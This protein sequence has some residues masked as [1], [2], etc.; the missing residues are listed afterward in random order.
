MKI[1]MGSL[2]AP[3]FAVPFYAV[4]DKSHEEIWLKGGRGSG[5][6]S[7]ISLDII[8]GLMQD[9]EA[10]AIVYRKVAETLR[11]SVYAQMVWALDKL[12]LLPFWQC[13]VSPMEIVRKKTGQRIVF[14]GADDP[15]KSKGIKLQKGYFKFLWFEE[16]TEFEGME[17]V[18]TIKASVIRGREAV[19]LYSYNPPK[20]A[21]N[22]VNGEALTPV[23]GRLTHQSTYLDIPRE[24]LGESFIREAE[25][26]KESNEIAYRHM[27]LG[28]VTGTGG[29]VFDN[30]R[31]S[32]LWDIKGNPKGWNGLHTYCGHDFGFAV[33]PDAFV[34]CAYDSRR[35]I[36]YVVDEYTGTGLSLAMLS[37]ELEKRAKRQVITADS[38]EPRSI[39]ELQARG[40]RIIGAKKGPDSVG[41]GMRW[42]ETLQGIVID[43]KRCPMAAKEFGG[44]EYDRDKNGQFISRYPDKNNH[45]IDAVRYAMESV[46]G[47]KTAIAVR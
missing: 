29:Q 17:A 30:V 45:M 23:A 44:Y 5:K 41:N 10:N 26:L 19:T 8:W 15:Q 46:R 38:A 24:W 32:T 28:E 13:K 12:G 14:R 31:L 22:W 40:L 18:R 7:F 16:L 11:D 25:A 27:Y 37:K 2:I 36:L 39:A 47:R 9:D 3:V 34:R 1:E 42:L 20:S 4:E 21:Q 43:P 33:D 35:K 6:S